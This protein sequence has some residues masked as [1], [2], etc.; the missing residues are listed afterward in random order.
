VII[1]RL[2]EL[3]REA[4]LRHFE[5][6]SSHDLYLRFC[7]AMNMDSVSRYVERLNVDRDM[8]LGAFDGDALVG[9]CHLASPI[10]GFSEVG[11]SMLETHRAQ[12]LGSKMMRRAKVYARVMGAKGIYIS[13]MSENS[14]M[15]ALARR[16]GVDLR[17]MDGS[18]EGRGV[19][20][21]ADL[22]QIGEAVRDEQIGVAVDAIDAMMAP[23]RA[24]EKFWSDYACTLRSKT[25]K[26]STH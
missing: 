3:H 19:S 17:L 26:L 21:R 23:T 7:T 1:R 18:Y 10:D 15:I 4:V 24:V 6:L 13:C 22:F 5:R 20:G 12:G 2:S 16:N 8:L 25:E 14:P 11:I 9:F